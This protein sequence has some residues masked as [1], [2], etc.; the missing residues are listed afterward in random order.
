MTV[1]IKIPADRTEKMVITGLPY[2][3]G[4]NREKIAMLRAMAGIH[5]DVTYVKGT[6]W[7]VARSHFS[8]LSR[9]LAERYGTVQLIHDQNVQEKCTPWCQEADPVNADKCQCVCLGLQHGG[10]YVGRRW[11]E[12][13]DHLLVSDNTVR[14]MRYTLSAKA[15]AKWRAHIEA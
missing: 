10:G 2:E 5:I 12:V 6:G 7:L 3:D 13:G 9:G 8:A 11:K 14:R 4:T 15:A 1:L